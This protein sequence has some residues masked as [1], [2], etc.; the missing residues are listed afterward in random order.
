[1]KR[2]ALSG[3]MPN[4]NAFTNVLRSGSKNY[5]FVE[6]ISI[7][8][9][10]LFT[11]AAS[12]KLLAYDQFVWQ[13]GQSPTLKNFAEWLAWMV[14]SV[15]LLISILLIVPKWRSLGLKASFGL[16]AAFTI[17]IASIL[18]FS[19]ELPCSCGGIL[20]QMSWKNHLVFNIIFTVL[21]LIAILIDK[22]KYKL[23]NT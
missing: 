1:M 8:I 22:G 21:P 7:L 3:S 2:S 14:P 23:N 15:E 13:I 12:S 11:Y 4:P 20:E 17:Y 18:S 9:I 5:I 10:L 16:M 19:K 6:I